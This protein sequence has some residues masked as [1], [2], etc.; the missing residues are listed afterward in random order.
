MDH[1]T[2]E[3]FQQQFTPSSAR[4]VNAVQNYPILFAAHSFDISSA[5]NFAAVHFVCA[6]I[7]R[8][9]PFLFCLARIEPLV[10]EFRADL[11]H[12]FS[13][14]SQPVRPQKLHPVPLAR[15]MTG[16]YHYCPLGTKF[17]DH[18]GCPRR[19][20][21]AQVDYVES[22]LAQRLANTLSQFTTA[23]PTVPGQDYLARFLQC[24]GICSPQLLGHFA[25]QSVT[26]YAP[27][28][29]NADNQLDH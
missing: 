2:A 7:L 18:Q 10:P 19:T 25:V 20:Y 5:K 16:R 8:Y 15:I 27:H 4:P 11:G 23:G 24:A 13:A 1:F 21:Y 3:F 17:S 9:L 28:S 12:V 14:D 26:D 6:V 22:H 29:G